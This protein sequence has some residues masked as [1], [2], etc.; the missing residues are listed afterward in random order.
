MSNHDIFTDVVTSDGIAAARNHVRGE[1]TCEF[2][3]VG[4]DAYVRP[5]T[6][7]H[8]PVHTNQ[9]K[10]PQIEVHLST[11]HDGNIGEIMGTVRSALV[12]AGLGQEADKMW[13][14]IFQAESYDESLRIV[15]RWVNVT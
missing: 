14:E 10:Y 12:R 4:P 15:M 5:A 7:P 8:C 1:C 9:P 13:A 2:T 6:D 11:G 3:P